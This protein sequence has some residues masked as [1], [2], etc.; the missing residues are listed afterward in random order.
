MRGLLIWLLLATPTMA[1]DRAGIFDYYVL[2]LSWSPNWCAYEGDARGSD[3]CDA[4]HDHGWILHGL[5]PQYHRGYPEYCPTSQRAPSRAM[6]RDM[7]DIMGTSGL[8]WHQ[9]K[10]HGVC[11]GL[12]APAYY[13]LS[14]EAYDRVVRPEVFRKLDRTVRLPASVVEEAFLQSNPGMEPDGV[15]ITCRAGHIQEARICLSR[16]LTPV[17]CGQDVVRDCRAKDA[18]FTP[19]R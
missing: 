5:W 12:S 15:T 13:A 9:W 4:R 3:Q 7:A 8:A 6:T 10:K 11:T 1:E 17:P 16:D 2:S 18:L 19:V 14:R